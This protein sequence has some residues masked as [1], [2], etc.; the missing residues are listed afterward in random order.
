M[1]L[2]RRTANLF[3]RSRVHREIDV[4]LRSHIALRMEDNLALG[5][6]PDEARRDVLLRFGNP[7]AIR[8]RVVAV[9]AA[10]ALD[11]V[12]RDI[13]YALRQ[14]RR[15]PAFA[16]TAI[17]T[18]MLGIGANV[19][20]FG[21]LNAVLLSPLDVNDPQGLYQLRHKPWTQGR[22]L[23]TSY[24]A[25]EDL[26]RRNNT[27][28]D[29]AAIYAYSAAGLSWDGN[30]PIEVHGDEVTGNYFDL[31]GVRPALGRL[32]HEADEHGPDSAPYLVLSDALWRSAFHADPDIVG[33]TVELSKRPFTV[34]GVA[35]P[36]FHGTE[37]F[38]WPDYWMPMVNEQQ[39]EGWD[40]LHERTSI[41]TTVIG[42]LKPGATP[43]QATENLNAIAAQLAKEYP[44]SDEALPLRLIHPGLYG[45]DADVIRGFLWSVTL[46]ALLVLVAACANLASLFAAR[47]ADR[48]CEFAVRVALGS[49]WQRLAQ[50]QLTQAM[51]VA[52]IG[53]AAGLATAALL[54]HLLN[55]WPPAAQAHLA[56]NLDARV[57]LAGLVLSLASALLFG[58]LPALQTRQSSPLQSMKSGPIEFLRFR[59]LASRDLLLGAQIAIC[60]LMVTASL[61]AVRGLKRTLNMPMGFHPKGA[62][63]AQMD[64]AQ[65][66]QA[67]DAAL[68]KE[69][70]MLEA[71]RGIPGVT[72]VGMVN[73]MPMTGGHGTPIYRAG[74]TEFKLSDAALAPY[75]YSISPGYLDAADTRLLN[76]R[77]I[78]W[79][80]T[81]KTPY[82]AIINETFAKKMWNEG[83]AIGEHFILW[84]NLTEV[85]GVAEN[86]KYHDL[87]ESPQPAVYLPYPQ[88]NS[89]DVNVVVRSQR[90]SSEMTAALEHT[91]SSI[92][93]NVPIT[94][95]SW[96]DTLDDQLLPARAATV[97]LG[98]MGLLAAMLAVTGIFGMAA[99]NVS[100]RM[101][102]LG[103]RMVM[104]ARR[105]QLMRAAV[106]RPLALLATGSMLG[107]G[108]GM[109]A[110]GLLGRLVYQANTRDP[111]V[112]VGVVGTM[113]LLGALAVWVPARRAL[114]VNPSVL[115][116]E[117]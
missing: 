35:P 116:R 42:R 53:G 73:R 1:S 46:L 94:V 65:V 90:P 11:G 20:V 18:L 72:A 3:G 88:G 12:V 51:M 8:E 13:R 32:F 21:V 78:S 36:H 58:M 31:L 10:L 110:S 50:Q 83:S 39:L 84:G 6:S 59:R 7:I 107:L 61:V 80:D 96:S 2:I 93:P 79:R 85:V 115:M 105:T 62:M 45:D 47:T 113:T 38:T 67:G 99:Y 100:R 9:D 15:T 111:L 108:C 41:T 64:L 37:R 44:L 75:V 55:R 91:L 57:Y 56:A 70:V 16:A 28:I 49:S 69:K 102:E 30:A 74:T 89:T 34:V 54:L 19:V 117:E 22:L 52:L 104:G 109:L 17:L 86:G 43:E 82:V 5:M 101:K 103:I 24:P 33:A 77:D 106:G 66:G 25:F 97:A 48:S 112:L 98:V 114:M 29:M 40:Y 26:R 68:E 14:L 87:Q 27:F 71:A 63:L 92:E 81:A 76:G 23:T 95:Q 60:T 4:E